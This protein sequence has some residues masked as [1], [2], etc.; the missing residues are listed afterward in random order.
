MRI[1]CGS[2]PFANDR[3]DKLILINRGMNYL[4]ESNMKTQSIK[5]SFFIT[6]GTVFGV[7]YFDL[8][9]LDKSHINSEY[10][11]AVKIMAKECMD[12]EE[13]NNSRYLRLF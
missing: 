5:L 3:S 9:F 8:I 7:G 10:K 2:N 12:A 11:F 4:L 1:D 6:T 13:T